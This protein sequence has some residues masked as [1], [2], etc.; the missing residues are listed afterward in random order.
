M[1][2]RSNEQ[3]AKKVLPLII[4][5]AKRPQHPKII[6]KI[7]LGVQFYEVLAV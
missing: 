1:F 3:P 2:K 4:L 6:F 5:H 7:H